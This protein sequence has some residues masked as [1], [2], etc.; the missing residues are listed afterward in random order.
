MTSRRQV[1]FAV[2]SLATIGF[3]GGVAAQADYPQRVVKIVVGNAPGGNDDTITRFIADR[4][5]KEFGQPVIVENRVG[6]STSI[7]GVAVATAPPDGYTLMCLIG[8]GIVQTVL[9][10]KLPYKLSS[11]VP[12]VGIGGFPLGLAVSATATPKITNL[13][14]LTAVARSADGITYAS[15]GVGT[16]AH[17]NTVRFLKAIQGKGVHV[18]YRNNPEGLNALVGGFTQMMFGSAQE[19]AALRGEDKLRVLAVTSEQRLPNL[20]DVPT[21]RELGFPAINPTLWYGYVA[22][23]GTPPAIVSK[24]ADAI[25]RAVRDPSFQ[26]RYK[27]LSFVE[28]IKTGEALTSFI[29]AEA[30]RWKE[31]II[32]NKIRVE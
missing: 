28:D 1:L 21:M 18:S 5:T 10:E 23:A 30:A 9:R 32:E 6:G 7:A 15:G 12:I 11:F 20:P 8:T 22:P 16:M 27:P 19:V 25:T 4:L 29:N 3:A 31:V 14:E 2:P 24:L 13:Q 26:N 17:L